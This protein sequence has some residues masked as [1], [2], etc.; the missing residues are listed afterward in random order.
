MLIY[1]SKRQYLNCYSFKITESDQE[2]AKQ[3]HAEYVEEMEEEKK[4]KDPKQ[5][6]GDIY[7]EFKALTSV[8]LKKQLGSSAQLIIF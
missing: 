8:G 7:C 5:R 3:L 2:K 6:F 1:Q 4:A